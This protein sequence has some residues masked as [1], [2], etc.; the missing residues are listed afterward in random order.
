MRKLIT[1]LIVALAFSPMA[2]ADDGPDYFMAV[3]DSLNDSGAEGVAW[4]V[5]ED[6]KYLTVAIEASG[7]EPSLVHPQHIHGFDRP[8]SNSSCPGPEADAN[9]DGIVSVG[10]GLPNYGPVVLP[11]FPFN[12][13]D[14]SGELSYFAAFTI[15]PEDLRPLH[16]RSIVL[17]GLTVDGEYVPSVPV[18]CGEIFE[19]E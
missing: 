9:G 2:A 14:G 12:L 15:R 13:V 4:I 8:R 11:L 7:L 10:E 18:A 19:V 16:K 1:G 6:G 17:H 5:V 3:L